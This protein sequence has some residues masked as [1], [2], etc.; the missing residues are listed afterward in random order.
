LKTREQKMSEKI[1]VTTDKGRTQGN[2]EYYAEA[3]RRIKGIRDRYLQMKQE[4]GDS[5][6]LQAKIAG[7][8]SKITGQYRIDS[9]WDAAV[10]ATKRPSRSTDPKG[11]WGRKV[12]EAWVKEQPPEYERIYGSPLV[13]TQFILEEKQ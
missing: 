13:I 9:D 8:V 12:F 10:K 5:E 11:T 7:A 4:S 1:W 2:W 3:D 6:K